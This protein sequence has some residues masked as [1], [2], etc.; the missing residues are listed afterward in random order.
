MVFPIQSIVI[1][2]ALLL[3][4]WFDI[5]T[6]EVPD[7]LSYTFITTGLVYS[8][9]GTIVAYNY[10]ILLS[11]LLG[12]ILMLLISLGLFYTGQWGGGDSK[13]L[14]GVGAWLGLNYTNLSSTPALAIFLLNLVLIGGLYGLFWALLL[15]IRHRV[16]FVEE[17]LVLVKSYLKLRAGLLCLALL[18]VILALALPIDARFRLLFCLLALLAIIGF[19]LWVGVKAIEKACF[20]K[21][22]SPKE[23]TEGDWVV[24]PVIV[25][26]KE[27]VKVK[28][29]GVTKEQIQKLIELEG[30]GKLK[31]VVVKEGI[32]FVPSLLLAYITTLLFQNWVWGL[33]M[34]FY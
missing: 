24:E 11:S 14:M 5:K 13:L 16:K 10:T 3:S 34:G 31:S 1:C 6:R 2:L 27:I 28:D 15:I 17:Y 20:Y 25:N 12:L 33:F 32:P 30:K 8:A 21:R 22:I 4:S 23:L 26:G 29:F 19:H 9:I 18:M 7:T